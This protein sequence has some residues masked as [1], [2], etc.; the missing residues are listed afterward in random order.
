MDPDYYLVHDST[1]DLPYDFY[2]PGIEGTKKPIYLLM[3]DGK[4]RELSEESQIVEAIAGRIKVDH[5]VYYPEE[6]FTDERIPAALRN[7]IKQLIEEV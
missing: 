1:S 2:R 7:E 6:L 4:Q 5:K 3:Q